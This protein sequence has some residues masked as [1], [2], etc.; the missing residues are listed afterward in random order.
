MQLLPSTARL[1]AKRAKLPVPT[2]AQLLLP[3]I[4]VPLGA[5]Y[6]ADLLDRFGGDTALASAAYNAGP[7]A[8]QRW[9]PGM[10]LDLDVW[11]ENI[12]FNE[13]RTYVQRVAW[14]ALVFTWLDKRKPL[15]VKS[16]LRSVGGTSP[17][18]NARL[19]E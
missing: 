11:V 13:T 1:A 9:V 2:R 3:A 7:I 15:E 10:P 14:H 4:N 16:W 8:A 17:G 5:A 6:L 19:A 18:S 12:P